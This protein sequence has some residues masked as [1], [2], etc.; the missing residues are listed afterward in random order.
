MALSDD[1]P[2]RVVEAVVWAGVAQCGRQAFW[3]E[4]RKRGALGDALQDH[5]AG[6][7]FAFRGRSP[8]RSCRGVAR[9]FARLDPPHAGSHPA[10]DPRAPDPKLRRALLGFRAGFFVF[11][12]KDAQQCPEIAEAFFDAGCD[13][14]LSPCLTPDD[15]SAGLGAAGMG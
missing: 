11:D 9:L 15:L 1:L 5:G 14:H 3:C 2:K 10:R 6:F 12:M 8:V 7:A 13:V 4:H